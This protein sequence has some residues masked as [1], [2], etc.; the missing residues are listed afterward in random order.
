M[1]AQEIS[2]GNDTDKP[3]EERILYQHES[4]L[5]ATLNS[6]GLGLGYRWGKIRN[7]YRTTNWDIEL[8][9]L[10]S[11]K[12]IRI[13]TGTIFN[14]SS[15]VYGKMNDALELRGGYCVENRIY[16][17]PYWGG[18]ELRWL[19]EFGATVAFLKPYYYLVT[20]IETSATGTISEVYD[21]QTFDKHEQWLDIYGRAPIKY[22]LDEIRVR[23]GIYAKGGLSFEIGTSRT[24]A[25]ALEVGT[26]LEYF[27]QGLQLMAEN[28]KQYLF[29]TF[30]LSYHWGS[31]FNK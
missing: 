12:Q 28:P 3:I 2:I 7:I 10:R 8:A 16:G 24:R 31:R 14:T 26:Q 17:K 15:F 21:Y 18:V 29:L 20:V 27:P 23:P 22:G 25:Q 6:Q 19:Y 1:E 9:Y 11:L 30:Y 13:I 5:H 4:T